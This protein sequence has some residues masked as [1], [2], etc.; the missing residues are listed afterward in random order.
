MMGA[1]YYKAGQVTTDWEK[2]TMGAISTNPAL[3]SS[4]NSRRNHPSLTINLESG[5]HT[6]HATFLGRTHG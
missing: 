4:N 3:P 1:S 5:T 6:K 2:K